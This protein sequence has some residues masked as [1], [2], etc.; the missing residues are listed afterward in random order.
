MN[1]IKK[2]ISESLGSVVTAMLLPGLLLFA[3]VR[4]AEAERLS[5]EQVLAAEEGA[6]V[7]NELLAYLARADLQKGLEE[8]GISVAEAR[9]RVASL[10]D[11]EAQEVAPLL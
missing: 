1:A 4:V 10:S 5:T 9:A 8:Q 2:H 7:R 11:A 3:P 6:S